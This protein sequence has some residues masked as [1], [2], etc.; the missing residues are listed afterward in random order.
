MKNSLL[1]L[2]EF[3]QLSAECYKNKKNPLFEEV[4]SVSDI[5]LII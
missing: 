4:G 1:I 5:F 3:L 2:K